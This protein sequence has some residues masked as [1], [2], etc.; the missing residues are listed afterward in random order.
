M[1]IAGIRCTP[2]KVYYSIVQFADDDSFSLI[3]QELI[4]PKSFNKPDKLKYIRKTILDI[5]KEYNIKKAGIR[6]IENNAQKP[7]RFRLMLEAVIQ[8]LI[9]SSYV[10]SYF[11]GLKGSIRAKLSIANDG[12]ITNLIEATSIF[13][14]ISDWKDFSTEHRECILVGFASSI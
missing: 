4:I 11:T 9:A 1:N 12:E 8:E 7:D 2:Q 3:N 6:I 14:G 10:E 13:N 5:F